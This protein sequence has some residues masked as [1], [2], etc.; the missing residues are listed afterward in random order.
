MR[1]SSAA[2][3][4]AVK[5][6]PPRVPE[7]WI[8]P[9]PGRDP[10]LLL[11]EQRGVPDVGV[12]PHVA[13]PTGGDR[14]EVWPRR[15]KGGIEPE[16]AQRSPRHSAVALAVVP[17]SSQRVLAADFHLVLQAREATA[18]SPGGCQPEA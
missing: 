18:P 8:E 9:Q 12:D 4:T 7:S 5:R 3:R 10:D 16:H 13:A 11:H 15:G 14:A 2:S 1:G 17:P 6:W